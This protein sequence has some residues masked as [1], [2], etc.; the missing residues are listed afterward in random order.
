MPKKIPEKLRAA[1]IFVCPMIGCDAQFT[2]MRWVRF[3]VIHVHGRVIDCFNEEEWLKGDLTGYKSTPPSM[4]EA[5]E[6]QVVVGKVAARKISTD[7]VKKRLEKFAADVKDKS[8]AVKGPVVNVDRRDQGA[9]ARPAAGAV[10]GVVLGTVEV[11]RDSSFKGSSQSHVTVP[12]ASRIE[13]KGKAARVR[14]ADS[15]ESEGPMTSKAKRAKKSRGKGKAPKSSATAVTKKPVI[16]SSDDEGIEEGL[17]WGRV[18]EEIK[19]RTQRPEP[20]ATRPAETIDVP[21]PE[22]PVEVEPCTRVLRP[23]CGPYS[24]AAREKLRGLKSK[25]EAEVAA[26]GGRIS[27]LPVRVPSG[28]HMNDSTSFS[29]SEAAKL[30]RI[31]ETR[32]PKPLKISEVMEI[33]KSNFP[34]HNHVEM[35]RLCEFFI[36]GMKYAM[37]RN[38]ALLAEPNPEISSVPLSAQCFREMWQADHFSRHDYLNMLEELEAYDWD[39]TPTPPSDKESGK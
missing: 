38:M 30:R 14:R 17:H 9:R 25:M 21:L 39:R 16:D 36:S 22:K 35:L 2:T 27:P 24:R 29:A 8:K 28:T 4:F 19:R 18:A 13:D 26:A 20:A 5:I 34:R 32:C 6:A 37:R 12:Q 31:L 3:H 33:A 7:A 10:K 1:G 23:R 11:L 15:S